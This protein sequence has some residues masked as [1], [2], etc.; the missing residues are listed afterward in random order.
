[1]YPWCNPPQMPA[2]PGNYHFVMYIYDIYVHD[3]EVEHSGETGLSSSNGFKW[4]VFSIGPP[5]GR[6]RYIAP[7]PSSWR[8]L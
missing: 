6:K 8:R 3:V 4:F 1:M 7:Q 2:F 5:P